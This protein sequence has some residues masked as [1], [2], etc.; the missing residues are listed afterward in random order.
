MM[1]FIMETKL[2][3]RKIESIK[4]KTRFTSCF[5]VDNVGKSGR[6]ALLWN[7]DVSVDIQNYSRGH[8]KVVVKPDGV[9]LAWTFTG[10][11]GHPDACKRR[12]SWSLLK[13]LHSLSLL[14]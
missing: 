11:Y 8:I 1:V 2:L 10:F 4:I 3:A 14:A 7:N 12:E 6:L 13:Y 9:S 5:G